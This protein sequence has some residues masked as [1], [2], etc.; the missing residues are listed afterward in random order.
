MSRFAWWLGSITQG[1]I[2]GCGLVLAL[3]KLTQFATGTQIFRYQ[4][5]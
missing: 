2:L 3:L 1:V 4:G 5:F